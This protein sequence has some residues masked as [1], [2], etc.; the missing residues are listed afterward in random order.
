MGEFVLYGLD[1]LGK[2]QGSERWAG[3][4][5]AEAELMARGRL[6]TY[7]VVEV[8]QGSIRTLTLS[9]SSGLLPGG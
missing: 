2:V 4:T 1:S 5:Q 6:K 3:I 8:W 7:E 9:R